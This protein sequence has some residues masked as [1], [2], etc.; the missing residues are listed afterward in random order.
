MGYSSIE[1]LKRLLPERELLQLADDSEDASGTIDSPDVVA[2]LNEAVDQADREIDG[3]VSARYAVPLDPVP[4]LARN[5]SAELAVA[6]LLRRRGDL[7]EA[8]ENERVRVLRSL[9]KIAEG[10]M[11]LAPVEGDVETGALGGAGMVSSSPAPR[12]DADR[13]KKYRT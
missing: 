1:D 12:F 6:V 13:W 9:E 8:W 4:G 10:R 7:P 2:V 3:Y 11:H 5:F